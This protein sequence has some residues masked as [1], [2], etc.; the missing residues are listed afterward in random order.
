M[1]KNHHSSSKKQPSPPKASADLT[2]AE[3]LTATSRA[4]PNRNPTA[5]P[6]NPHQAGGTAT[7]SDEDE[8]E[9]KGKRATSSSSKD[10]SPRGLGHLLNRKDSGQRREKVKM[11][12]QH[13]QDHLHSAFKSWFRE[14]SVG[15]WWPV[16]NG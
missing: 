14:V 12:G 7:S 9:K 8:G 2:E 1:F 10:R 4:Q 15:A 13:L 16:V 5:T 3:I 11:V 6:L